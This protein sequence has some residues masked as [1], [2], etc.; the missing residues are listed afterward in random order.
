[1]TALQA[2]RASAAAR[3][4]A[5]VPRALAQETAAAASFLTRV[6][7]GRPADRTGA[8]AFGIVGA[9]V[10]V[11]GAIPL[12][13]VGARLPMPA[14][15]LALAVAAVASGALHL[16][17]LADTA[18]ALVAPSADA[19]ER[20]RID[21]GAGPA[22][23]AAVVLVLFLDA[24]LLAAIAAASAI[25]AAAALVVAA[26]GSRALAPAVALMSRQR[27]AGPMSFSATHR[28][29]LAVWFEARV[30]P[31]AALTTLASAVGVALLAG[32]IAGDVTVLLSG[33]LAGVLAGGF[34]AA[35][36]L[37]ARGRL[38]G[39]GYGAI[40]ELTFA[41]ILAAVALQG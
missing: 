40:V 26:A 30:R 29:S 19:A 22:G 7:M 15:V 10:G 27:S 2:R 28:S 1:M 14:A 35:A 11:A 20:A 17:G 33:L 12:L 38:D 32:V 34:G 6:P 41:A 13:L 4:L 23:V 5:G 18:D 8:A 36:I 16:D 25:L 9:V 39:D 37:R 3:Q 31:I 21:P 24:S